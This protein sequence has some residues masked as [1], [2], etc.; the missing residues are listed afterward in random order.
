L[1]HGRGDRFERP[2]IRRPKY[3][4]APF[5]IVALDEIAPVVAAPAL[6]PDERGARQDQTCRAD[7][8]R[9][10]RSARDGLGPARQSV[11]RLDGCAQRCRIALHTRGTPE[12][13]GNRASPIRR[14]DEGGRGA[15]VVGR[16]SISLDR[17]YIVRSARSEDKA[18][19]ERIR[20]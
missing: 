10:K 16:K 4:L 19:R 13:R 15:G 3:P 17:A 2:A 18:F 20:R 9:F 7:R 14:F 12:Q 6:F 5:C 8:P 11:E 1:W